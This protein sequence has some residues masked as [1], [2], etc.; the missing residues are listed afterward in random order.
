MGTVPRRSPKVLSGGGSSS[1]S[2]GP[3]S[4][5]LRPTAA[6]IGSAG[7]ESAMARRC[8]QGAS[9]AAAR[10]SAYL[11]AGNPRGAAP[12][13]DVGS[14][15]PSSHSARRF[16]AAQAYCTGSSAGALFSTRWDVRRR[17]SSTCAAIARRASGSRSWKTCAAS[18]ATSPAICSCTSR[19]LA[20]SKTDEF[21][22]PGAGRLGRSRE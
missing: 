17:T 20:R 5:G 1:G 11:G 3:A 10:A 9:P 4:G 6:G 21:L 14:S 13:G 18:C 19:L 7:P 16:S 15:A 2:S 8:S 22:S 12:R